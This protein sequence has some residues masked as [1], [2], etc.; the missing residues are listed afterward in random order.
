MYIGD[1]PLARLRGTEG[2]PRRG[3]LNIGQRRIAPHR[4]ASQHHIITR[5]HIASHSDGGVCL[6]A[7]R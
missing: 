6:R 1:G 4:I 7:A 5:R 3:A 2:V